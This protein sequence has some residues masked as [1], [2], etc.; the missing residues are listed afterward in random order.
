MLAMHQDVQE[1]C[2]NEIKNVFGDEFVGAYGYELIHDDFRKLDYLVRVIKETMRLF[3]FA[4]YL[5]RECSSD[6]HLGKI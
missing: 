4:P 5:A 2:Y 6:L 1:K 3:P